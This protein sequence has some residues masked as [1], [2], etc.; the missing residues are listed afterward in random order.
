MEFTMEIK[1]ICSKFKIKGK[2]IKAKMLNSGI[3]NNTY[4]VYFQ[5]N[6]K[7]EQYIIQRINQNV[8][9]KPALVMQNIL[10]ISQHLINKLR[11]LDAS[12]DRTVLHYMLADNNYAYY[13]DEEG[14]YWRCYRFIN[15]SVTYNNPDDLFIIEEAGKA[16][17]QF[18]SLLCDFDATT[19]H[20]SIPDFHNTKLRFTR[21]FESYDLDVAQRAGEVQAEIEYLRSRQELASSLCNKIE[22]KLLPIKVTHNDTKCNNVLFDQD[23]NEALAVIDLDT[24]M[25]GIV[26][27]DYGD[28][29]RCV[30]ATCEEDETD[31]NKVKIDMSKF[32]AFTKGF[33]SKVK[34]TLSNEEFDS[35]S[36]GIIVITL[37]LASRFLK[38]YLDG[39]IYFKIKYQGHNLVR[40]RCQIE[41][42]KEF[43]RHFD[44]IKKTIESYK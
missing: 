14:E 21:L 32:N 13:T 41:L 5:N 44:E 19:L 42:A 6:D 15:D 17:G 28:A 4:K 33:V 39:D 16:F 11:K 31:L 10:S 34:N 3:I 18:Q 40:A 22:N 27:Y 9:K 8:F 23:T 36:D 43:E 20:E 35:L 25:P 26:A 30:A 29:I 37:E 38:D 2:F 12:I 24:V 7:D 1:D